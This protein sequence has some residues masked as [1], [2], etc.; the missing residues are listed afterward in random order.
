MVCVYVFLEIVK[1]LGCAGLS[2]IKSRSGQK[3]IYHD[4]LGF[5]NNLVFPGTRRLHEHAH[6]HWAPLSLLC[7]TRPDIQ[8]SVTDIKKLNVSGKLVSTCYDNPMSSTLYLC[9]RAVSCRRNHSSPITKRFP[10]K[11]HKVS[12]LCS[13]IFLP[14][15]GRALWALSIRVVVSWLWTDC[16]S[17]SNYSKKVTH[18]MCCSWKY[19]LINQPWRHSIQI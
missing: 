10:T 13:I 9:Q 6:T 7:Q 15:T 11:S 14:G 16:S 2:F 18:S 8:L 17:I 4:R 19:C 1:E 5:H 12:C 3:G